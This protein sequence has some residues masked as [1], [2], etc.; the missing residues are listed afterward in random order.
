MA[1]PNIDEKKNILNILINA[2]P[3]KQIP[4]YC[5]SYSLGVDSIKKKNKNDKNKI[6]EVDSTLLDIQIIL[7]NYFMNIDIECEQVV[8]ALKEMFREMIYCR[9]KRLKYNIDTISEKFLSIIVESTIHNQTCFKCNHKNSLKTCRKQCTDVC[10]TNC[11]INIEIKMKKKSQQNTQQINLNSGIPEG[12]T[13]WKNKNGVLL[14][15]KDDGYSFVDS[16]HVSISNYIENLPDDWHVNY[17]KNKI[18]KTRMQINKENLE[19]IKFDVPDWNKYKD[20]ICFH[21][22]Y[23]YEQLFNEKYP[24]SRPICYSIEFFM[25]ILDKNKDKNEN[26]IQ[27]KMH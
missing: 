18:K 12:V 17:T 26:N 13:N 1:E 4:S 6:L 20:T 10:C 2:T 16:K 23:I 24:H 5:S 3:Q 8:D 7:M 27:T 15:F 22:N 19:N 21:L 9:L 11:G 14:V 25:S